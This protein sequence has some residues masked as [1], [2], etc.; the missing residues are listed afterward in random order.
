MKEELFPALAGQRGHGQTTS[1]THREQVPAGQILLLCQGRRSLEPSR[2][3][4]FSFSRFTASGKKKRNPVSLKKQGRAR[5][6]SAMHVARSRAN[7]KTRGAPCVGAARALFRGERT[8][9]APLPRRPRLTAKRQ[10]AAGSGMWRWRC[11]R[12]QAAVGLAASS[13]RPLYSSRR[14]ALGITSAYD[15]APRRVMRER[16]RGLPLRGWHSPGKS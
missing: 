1:N 4:L 2:G 6:L 14:I 3:N 12:V 10:H 9:L 7:K 11:G 16:E 15:V 13:C 5:L 8:H